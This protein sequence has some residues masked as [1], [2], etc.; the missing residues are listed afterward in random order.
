M[1]AMRS[2]SSITRMRDLVEVELA[3]LEQ[4]DHAARGR[5]RDLDAL[6]LQVAH[7]L[8]ERGAAV[9][10]GDAHADLLAERR[11]H[12]DDLLGELARR[13]EHERGGVAGLGRR[14]RSG[15]WAGRTRASCPS[16][17]GPCRTRRGRRAR[18]RWWPLGWRR[19]RRCPGPR[20]RRRTRPAGRDLGRS[21]LCCLLES[22][23]WR[24]ILGSSVSYFGTNE[25]RPRDPKEGN[26]KHHLTRRP[27]RPGRPGPVA[28]AYRLGMAYATRPMHDADSHIM[29]PPAGSKP[30][31]AA[32]YRGAASRSCGRGRRRARRRSTSIAL[33]RDARRSRVPRRGRVADHCCAR[34]SSRPVRSSKT[35]ARAR[36]TCSAS[37]ASSCSTRSRARTCCASNATAITS[38][39][40]RSRAASTGR[41]STGARSTRGC[42]RSCV[43]PLGDMPAAV[44]ARR[45]KRSTAARPRS[46]SASTARR[47]TRRATSSSS[48][49]GRCAAEA[50]VPVVLHVAGAG[51]NVMTL[52]FFEN[53]LPAGS[54]LPRRRHAT[55]SR[56]TTCRSRC[57]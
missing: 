53:G 10:R 46:R 41:C 30:Y 21:S 43:V 25:V 16:R 51:A 6:A 11:E 33:R 14:R 29:E 19:G 37:R 9:E 34:T 28:P 38:S 12:V 1:S 52:D 23:S 49:C 55:S 15:A 20:G 27:H 7:L 47:A 17:C 36:S 8:V 18:R 45:A 56:S 57:R 24:P 44:D 3:A 39:R 13:H 32:E 31:L 35:T 54:R 40:S 50:G 5:D 26:P 42:C 48:R 22:R 4:V 2:A